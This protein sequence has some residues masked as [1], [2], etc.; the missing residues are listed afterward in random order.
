MTIH[1][2]EPAAS[3]TAT[4]EHSGCWFWSLKAR[5]D[6][7]SSD[8]TGQGRPAAAGTAR[9]EYDDC[10]LESRSRN[11]DGSSDRSCNKSKNGWRIRPNVAKSQISKGPASQK[12]V[13]THFIY[14]SEVSAPALRP[15]SEAPSPEQHCQ[16]SI[17]GHALCTWMRRCGNHAAASLPRLKRGSVSDHLRGKGFAW[18]AQWI[19]RISVADKSRKSLP[20]RKRGSVSDHPRKKGLTWCSQ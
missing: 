8:N 17:H 2:K 16:H 3:G 7:R 15:T 5:Y 10:W 4:N 14:T 20:S 6:D 18:H 13:A 19:K 9:D 11:N 1:V 12:E